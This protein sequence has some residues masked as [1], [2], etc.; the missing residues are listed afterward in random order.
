MIIQ[1]NCKETVLY[2]L[3]MVRVPDG[4]MRILIEAT[5]RIVLDEFKR[6]NNLSKG[7]ENILEG[8]NPVDDNAVEALYKLAKSK[9]EK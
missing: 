6:E 3:K 2:I 4:S 9:F 8:E 7:L 5:K 1:M